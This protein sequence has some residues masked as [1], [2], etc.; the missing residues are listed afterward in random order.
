MSNDKL[1]VRLP[2]LHIG[3]ISGVKA[4]L[5]HRLMQRVKQRIVR[6]VYLHALIRQFQRILF[7]AQQQL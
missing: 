4:R 6:L 3:Q 2:Q 1:T 7:V 5:L